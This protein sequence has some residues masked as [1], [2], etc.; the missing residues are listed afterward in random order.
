MKE[1]TGCPTG[2]Y[3]TEAECNNKITSYSQICER[4]DT[5]GTTCY[6]MTAGCNTSF[7]VY[8][9]TPN[10]SFFN[11]VTPKAGTTTCYRATSCNTAAGAYI[12]SPSTTYFNVATSS[13]SGSTCYRGTSCNTDAGAFDKKPIQIMNYFNWNVSKASGSTCYR[14]IS[15]N[16]AYTNGR[17]TNTSVFNYAEYEASGRKCYKA[18]SCKSGYTETDNGTTAITPSAGIPCYEEQCPDGYFDVNPDDYDLISFSSDVQ[19]LS[20]GT[21]CYKPDGCK[22]SLVSQC[23]NVQ[24]IGNSEILG[25]Q[26]CTT[27]KEY[28]PCNIPIPGTSPVQVYAGYT[29]DPGTKMSEAMIISQTTSGCWIATGCKSGWKKSTTQLVSGTCYKYG[30]FICVKDDTSCPDGYYY[31]ARQPSTIIGSSVTYSKHA[32]YP[33]CYQTICN[34]EEGWSDGACP[35]ANFVGCEDNTVNGKTCHRN[36][37]PQLVVCPEGSDVRMDCPGMNYE[38]ITP[39][40]GTFGTCYRATS[41]KSG[42]S[43]DG[44]GEPCIDNGVTCRSNL[45]WPSQI[46]YTIDCDNCLSDTAGKSCICEFYYALTDST[47]LYPEGVYTIDTETYKATMT[48]EASG[49][50]F[51]ASLGTPSNP[52]L[53]GAETGI[54]CE[55]IE[56]GGF[57]AGSCS[58]MK[59]N[60]LMI[61]DDQYLYISN[62]KVGTRGFTVNDG[63][64]SENVE[65]D[66][67]I[68][69][70]RPASYIIK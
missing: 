2:Y 9:S 10:T 60:Y 25:E 13:A 27:Q 57:T 47:T 40:S 34:S 46:E 12:S 61:D 41:C 22:L 45:G 14:A 18:T 26:I 6:R 58:M 15:C 8:L 7:G 5:N 39:I 43:S 28:T 19:E 35:I 1:N 63:A 29:E 48:G 36:N 50:V 37:S 33:N 62:G 24:G 67:Y 21:K 65:L 23:I 64:T 70:I 20:D 44:I 31:S 16:T 54:R 55:S 69:Y 52:G 4:A 32:S 51:V 49:T 30:D 66:I 59:L 11:V 17:M 3:S 38:P 42:Y 53:I 68:K 56:A